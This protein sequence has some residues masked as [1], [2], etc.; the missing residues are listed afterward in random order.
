MKQ[1]SSLGKMYVIVAKGLLQWLY[2]SYIFIIQS[3][4]EI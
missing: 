3:E 2:Y 1:I 4:I